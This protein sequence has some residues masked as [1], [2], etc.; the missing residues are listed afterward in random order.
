M[1][2]A[3]PTVARLARLAPRLAPMVPRAPSVVRCCHTLVLL[4]HLVFF[5]MKWL[6]IHFHRRLQLCSHTALLLFGA[7][8]LEN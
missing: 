4:S 5:L 3:L 2:V 6:W 1:F 7:S 8:Y